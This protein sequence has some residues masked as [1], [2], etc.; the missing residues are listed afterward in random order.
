VIFF[1]LNLRVHQN[2]FFKKGGI[3]EKQGKWRTTDSIFWKW[4]NGETGDELVDANMRE[5]N[6]TAWMSNRG[7]QNVASY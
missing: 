3:Q 7:R 5:L 6:T 2:K 4:A 1:Q